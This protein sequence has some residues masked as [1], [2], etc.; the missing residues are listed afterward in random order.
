MEALNALYGIIKAALL[1]YLK[2]VKNLKSIGFELNTYDPCV[3]NNIVNGAQLTVV[4][5]VDDLKVS[6][7]D[8]GVVTQM[9]VWLQKT[10]E[11]LFNDSSGAMKLK[12]RKIHE[13]LGM[14]L[15]FSVVG[16][17][18][19]TMLEYI[20]EMLE[21]F[22]RFDPNKTISHTAAADHLFKVRDDQPKLDEQNAQVFHT[23]TAKSIFATKRARPDIHTSVAFLTTHVIFPDEDDWNKLL[24]MMRYLRDTK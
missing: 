9:P 13:Y 4:W 20:Q 14:Q 6:H 1:F 3:A 19:I 12:Q 11:R 17:V 7:M 16:Q 15:D 18:K 8:A 10:Y 5:Q 21:D 24:R 23:F 2:F 22:H